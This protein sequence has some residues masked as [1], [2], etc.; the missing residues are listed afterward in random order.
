MVK[1]EKLNVENIP[2]KAI[3]KADTTQVKN[4]Q[5][6]NQTSHKTTTSLKTTTNG[7]H[8]ILNA[9]VK[10][11]INVNEGFVIYKLNGVTLKNSN[12]N[13]KVNVKNSK[14]VLAVSVSKY[15]GLYSTSEAVYSGSDLFKKSR[16]LINNTNLVKHSTTTSLTTSVNDTHIKLKATVN[17][18]IPVY[19]GF[20]I[21]KL[22][23]IT[24]KDSSKENYKVEVSDSKAVLSLP[25]KDYRRFYSNSMAV[26]SGSAMY[27]NSRTFNNHTINLRLDPEISVVSDKSSYTP[28]E[29]VSLNVMIS[30]KETNNFTDGKVSIK[31]NGVSLKDENN[32]VRIYRIKGNSVTATF[33]IQ[34]GMKYDHVNVTVISEGRNYNQVST[35]KKI[36]VIPL[37]TKIVVTNTFIDNNNNYIINATIKDKHDDNVIGKRFLDFLVDNSKVRI[38]NK[39]KVYTIM[40]GKINLKIPL[41]QYKKGAHTVQ[42]KLR[43][44]N[45][46]SSS[47]ST[48]YNINLREKYQ[49]KIIIDTPQKAKNAS[50]TNLRF[51][52]T[53]DNNSILKTIN[54]GKITVKINNEVLTSDV[55]NGKA[56]ISHKLPNKIGTYDI[57]AYYYGI[58]DLK[59][60]SANKE[61]TLTS[62]SISSSESA[63][64]GNKDPKKERISFNS[65]GVPDL[66]YMTNY[67]WADDDATYTLSKSQLEEVFQ[68]D[69][70]SLYLNGHVSKYVAF[71]TINESNIY[72]V[73]KREKWNVIEKQA[74]KIRVK[75]NKGTLPDNI[76][77]SLKGKQ[78]TYAEARAIQSLG[79]TCGPTAASVCTQTLKNYVNEYTFAVEFNTYTYTGTY[80]RYI[81]ISMKLHNMTAEYYYKSNFESA[82]SKVAGGGYTFIFYGVNHYVSIIDVSKD[83]S[84]VLVSNS[85]GNYSMGGGKIP[86]GWVSVSYMKNRFSTDSFAGLLVSLHYSLSS[87]TKTKVNNLYNNFGTNWIRQNTNEELNV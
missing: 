21:Y 54:Q 2:E 17:S 43:G 44:D 31:L 11:D 73:L 69:S 47:S 63:I 28:G 19:N 46:Y 7:S 85:Y 5:K 62:N 37:N 87:D 84:K 18:D 81:P 24:L 51:Y 79:Y 10:S 77:V 50:Q 41:D 9:S 61:I 36:N 29:T 25:L 74:N 26:Y 68:Q 39:S 53:Y 3:E 78:Y 20:V 65:A 35:T 8:I 83:K 12:Q 16:K 82:L 38:N 56:I 59:D 4:A 13:I 64:L 57:N 76:T 40:N 49:T 30:D 66:I 55:N 80:A 14:A 71:R 75:S 48:L 70:F 33:P 6:N 1:K 60:S 23:R 86:N 15:N 27:S 58:D 22:N 42:L 72:H 45:A 67:V 34:K 32:K 52:V